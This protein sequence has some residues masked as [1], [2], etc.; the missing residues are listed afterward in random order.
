MKP[1]FILSSL[2]LMSTI[3]NSQSLDEYNKVEFQDVRE[4]GLDYYDTSA[5]NKELRVVEIQ[6]GYT[7]N[8]SYSVKMNCDTCFLYSIEFID[9]YKGIPT[10]YRIVPVSDHKYEYGEYK[11]MN[12][13]V[14]SVRL[15]NN[16]LG[17]TESYFF[18]SHE[19]NTRMYIDSLDE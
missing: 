5:Y 16:T 2:M 8:D 3:V 10:K 1:R 15:I 19:A 7:I 9:K 18:G 13:T 17:I 11:W 6:L 4:Y 12:D 14:V